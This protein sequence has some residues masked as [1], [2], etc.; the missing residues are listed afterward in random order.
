MN[1]A[2]RLSYLLQYL[3][4]EYDE[5][6]PMPA[7]YADQRI[8]LRKMVNVRPPRSVSDEFLAVQDAFLQQEARWRGVVDP[9]ELPHCPRDVRISLWQGDITRLRVDAIVNA[10]NAKL[11]GCFCPWHGCIDNAIHTFSG[12]QLRQA[13]HALMQEQGGDEPTGTAK[14][15]PA[16]NLPSR[17]VIHTVGPIVRGL[18]TAKPRDE[19][20]SC[21][22]S[23]LAL[24]AKHGLESIALCCISTGEYGF[25]KRQAAEIAAHTVNEFLAQ[26]TSLKRV[27][28][29]VFLDEDCLI[30]RDLHFNRQPFT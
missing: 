17:Y 16:F 27:V 12:V 30:Y 14:I 29:N 15:T 22:W 13:C 25:P 28:F 4:G 18:L 10:A 23:C 5:A 11:L 21:Y 8:L 19:L 20:A 6:I 24:A 26:N 3:C 9:T 7:G 2:Q 1:Q